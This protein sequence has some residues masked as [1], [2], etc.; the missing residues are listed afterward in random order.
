MQEALLLNFGGELCS[1][2]TGNWGFVGDQ[3]FS[4]LLNTL[5]DRIDV[6]WVDCLKIQDLCGDAKLF[7]NVI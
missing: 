2:S 6:V 5:N 3:A 7:L 1:K 4:G